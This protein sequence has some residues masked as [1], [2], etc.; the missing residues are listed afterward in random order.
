MSDA[1]RDAVNEQYAALC[2]RHGCA[3][4]AR[5]P[6]CH[7]VA[8]WQEFDTL[9]ASSADHCFCPDCGREVEPVGLWLELADRADAARSQLP[10][11]EEVLDE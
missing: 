7:A 8:D 5:C 9:G 4:P 6:A 3:E 1:E 2:R 10:L 11:Y